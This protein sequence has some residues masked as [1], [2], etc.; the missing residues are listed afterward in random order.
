M[1][2]EEFAAAAAAARAKAA[3]LKRNPAG[4]F[5]ASMLAGAFIGFGVLLAFTIGGLL[6]GAAYT[7]VLMGV[8]FGVALS[9][10]VMAG[11]ELFTGNNFV[12]TAGAVSGTVGWGGAVRLWL[13]CWLGNLAGAVLLAA[14]FYGAGLTDSAVGA[15]MASGAAGK[16]ALPRSRSSP[17]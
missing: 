17:L 7:K 16:M 1:F 8:S 4:Y 3:F 13:V 9:L 11:G 2:E 5:L 15:Y 6:E 12:M 14:M 10:V